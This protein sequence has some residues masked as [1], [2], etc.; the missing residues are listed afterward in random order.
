MR[1]S[2]RK[3]WLAVHL[4]AGVLLGGLFALLG[5]TGSALVF[6]LGVDE[7]LNPEIQASHAVAVPPSPEAVLR[8]LRLHFPERNG[9]WRIEMPLTPEAPVMARYYKPPERAG[10]FFSPLMVTLDPET[11]DVTSSRFWGDYAVTW[12]YDLHYTLLLD[13]GGRTAVGIFGLAM[14]GSLGTG[15]FLW[16]P[17]RRRLFAALRLQLRHG[18]ARRI[19]DLHVLN[20]IYFWPV[21]LVLALTGS[22][23]ALPDQTRSM[24]GTREHLHGPMQIAAPVLT[25]ETLIDLDMAGIVAQ[26]RFP[27]AEV[28][29]VESSGIGGTPISVRLH[30]PGEPGRRFPHTQIWLHPETGKILA[31]HDPLQNAAADSVLDWLHPLHNGEAF[32][33]AGRLIVLCS[34]LVLPLLFVTGLMRWRQKVRAGRWQAHAQESSN[35]I[36]A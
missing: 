32:G 24:L 19:Y 15:L 23:L 12:I 27:G 25:S 5:I 26:S 9:P 18:A 8:K 31:L 33:L 20:G 14:L 17:S 35:E 21:M 36:T 13:E 30:Q 28:R 6:Y 22:A 3:Y 10:R 16:W 29:W 1:R 2:L 11:L 7:T 4:Y 34:G